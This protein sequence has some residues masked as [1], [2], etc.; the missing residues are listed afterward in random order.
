MTAMTFS[1]TCDG[2]L[3]R[4]SINVDEID[5]AA[6][7]F[8]FVATS[9]NE[10]STS[11]TGSEATTQHNWISLIICVQ[12]LL[13]SKKPPQTSAK[14]VLRVEN[15]NS[16]NGA[17]TALLVAAKILAFESTDDRTS[18]SSAV[19]QVLAKIKMEQEEEEAAAKKALLDS[20]TTIKNESGNGGDDDNN[21]G[22]MSQRRAAWLANDSVSRQVFELLSE[23][24]ALNIGTAAANDKKEKET[25]EISDDDD[26]DS[27]DDDALFQQILLEEEE[28]FFSHPSRQE[29]GT[30]SAVYDALNGLVE[31]KSRMLLPITE[32]VAA[33]I[34]AQIPHLATVY[35]RVVH[36]AEDEMLFWVSVVRRRLFF[37]RTRL[38]RELVEC[39]EELCPL[40]LNP[41][42]GIN[43]NSNNNNKKKQAKNTK[44]NKSNDDETMVE[45]QQ[46]NNIISNQDD[47]LAMKSLLQSEFAMQRAPAVRGTGGDSNKN[48][49]GSDNKNFTIGD[50]VA[51]ELNDASARNVEQLALALALS[52]NSTNKKHHQHENDEEAAFG[53]FED[54]SGLDPAAEMARRLHRK[55][56]QQ[57]EMDNGTSGDN[58][59]QKQSGQRRARSPLRT[60]D[61]YREKQQLYSHL[62]QKLMTSSSASINLQSQQK[63][64]EARHWRVVWVG[65]LL[66]SHQQT[67]HHHHQHFA[68]SLRPSS[69]AASSSSQQQQLPNQKSQQVDAAAAPLLDVK[70]GLNNSSSA[71]A[72]AQAAAFLTRVFW[73]KARDI[74]G[75]KKSNDSGNGRKRN[76]KKIFQR[77]HGVRTSLSRVMQREWNS[78]QGDDPAAIAAEKQLWGDALTQ[79]DEL[80]KLFSS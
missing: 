35:S 12:H 14:L 22:V 65:S 25:I 69:V 31:P 36:C 79:M 67:N 80:L 55:Q 5:T 28:R 49:S 1:C 60:D 77:L 13:V 54:G 62:S 32:S 48:N 6:S 2:I 38:D 52:E 78:L 51:L 71:C 11:R 58:N 29:I 40:G 34:F 57:Q 41:S 70:P 19:E 44:T 7:T 72:H 59:T 39:G 43:N 76:Q 63:A 73:R 10:N 56:Q 53:H 61:E 37:S 64:H 33:K 45:Q 4:L 8:G 9:N 66:P 75:Q 30:S 21:G 23:V 50:Q 16:N 74:I 42:G 15:T 68:V 18:F 27:D 20:A 3:G 46:S 26:D 17:E 47:V 24:A